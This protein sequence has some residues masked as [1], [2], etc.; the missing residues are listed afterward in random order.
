M[1]KYR[2][3]LRLSSM[4]ISQQNIAYSCGVSKK[5]VNKV[6]KRAREM[7]ISWPLDVN[8]TDAVLAEKL[9]PSQQKD[10]PAGTKRKPDILITPEP[11]S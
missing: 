8:Q 6:L 11:C 2:E 3:I 5:T 9:F 10:E 4:G 7:D 1:T